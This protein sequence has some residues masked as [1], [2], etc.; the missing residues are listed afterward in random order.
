MAEH[1]RYARNRREF[2]TECFCGAG[3]L[4]FA[5]MMA[6]SQARAAGYN[7]LAP[8]PPHMPDKARAKAF[9]FLYMAGGPSHLETFDHKPKLAAMHG[10]PMPD[11][12][13]KGQQLA[14]LQGAKLTCFGPQYDFQ[15]FGKCGAEICELFPKIGS[16]SADGV[17]IELRRALE[18]WNVLAEEAASHWLEAGR[19]SLARSALTEATRLLRRG[20]EAL[21]RLPPVRANLSLRLELSGL[22]GPAL[23]GLRGPG[24][25]EAQELYAKAYAMCREVPEE[26][27]PSG[28]SRVRSPAQSSKEP[29]TKTA[30]AW[31]A[32]TRKLVPSSVRMAPIPAAFDGAVVVMP[33]TIAARQIWWGV[34]ETLLWEGCISR[35]RA[36]TVAPSDRVRGVPRDDNARTPSPVAD[37]PHRLDRDGGDRGPVR[38][39]DRRDRH[40]LT[41][42]AVP[43]DL[44]RHHG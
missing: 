34:A 32:Q 8:K 7:P 12:L 17:T 11:S 42:P 4:A 1:V 26:P 21:E 2:L 15:K 22:L 36:G 24:S 16:I 27:S 38:G 14:Q 31:G 28:L 37:S 18:P 43:G 23:I 30:S 20:L 5:Q 35:S 40:V 39:W 44:A 6:Q 29:V 13:T 33:S 25:P 3:S 10:Q 9:I 41:L 19:R